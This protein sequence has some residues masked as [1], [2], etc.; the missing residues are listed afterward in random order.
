MDIGDLVELLRVS[1]ATIMKCI[2][3][4]RIPAYKIAKGKYLITKRQLMKV[5]EKKSGSVVEGL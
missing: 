5:I 3:D 2:D 4:G 1:R